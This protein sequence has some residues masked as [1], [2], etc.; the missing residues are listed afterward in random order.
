MRPAAQSPDSIS[1]ATSTTRRWIIGAGT[2]ATYA[3]TLIVLNEAWY[4]D[5]PKSSFHT[6]NDGGEWL[7]M[8]KI[9]HGWTAYNSSRLGYSLWRWSGVSPRAAVWLGTSSSLA[10]MLSIEYLDGRSA[11]WGW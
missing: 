11:E 10:Y 9:G 5:Y 4:K 7:Q 2:A 1:S 6:F 8:D 3:S